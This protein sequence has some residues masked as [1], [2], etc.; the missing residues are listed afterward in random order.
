MFRPLND[1]QP[2]ISLLIH[3]LQIIVSQSTCGCMVIF[4]ISSRSIEFEIPLYASIISLMVISTI[5]QYISNFILY[6]SR[7][8]DKHINTIHDYMRYMISL[9]F[10]DLAFNIIIFVFSILVNIYI[11]QVLIVFIV[12][13]INIVYDMCIITHFWTVVPVYEN[14]NSI[15]KTELL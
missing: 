2:R 5:I 9:A 7:G 4:A 8:N 14:N 12:S 1:K 3:I 10:L 11:W 15:E 13:M 6:L